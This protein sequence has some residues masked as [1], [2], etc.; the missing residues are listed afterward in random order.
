[1][2]PLSGS[3]DSRSGGCGGFGFVL[4]VFLLDVVVYIVVGGVLPSLRFRL[5]RPG[6]RAC[7]RATRPSPGGGRGGLGLRTGGLLGD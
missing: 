1:M 2:L 3:A 7:C 5:Y 6:H 4:T